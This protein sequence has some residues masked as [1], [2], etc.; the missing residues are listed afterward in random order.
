MIIK[1]NIREAVQ[2][3]ATSKQ[4]TVLALIGIIIGIGS[5]IAM[6]SIGRIVQEEALRQFKE[7][8]TDIVTIR[9]D[10][11]GGGAGG[12][13]KEAIL[14]MKEV[15]A[16]P[17]N[18]PSILQV[19]PMAFHGGDLT[20]AGKKVN[21]ATIIGV[22]QSFADLNKLKIANGRFLSDFDEYSN[23]CVLGNGAYEKMRTLVKGDVIGSSLRMGDRL[24][25]VIG[26][27][28]KMAPSSIRPFEPNDTLYIHISTVMRLKN[29]NDVSAVISRV[30]PDISHKLVQKEVTDYFSTRTKITG[31]SVQSPEDIIA[32][33]EKQMR[34]FTL[35]LG[36][37]GSISLIV[38]GVGVMNVML[39]S[40]TERRKEIGIRRALGARQSDIRGQFLIESVILSM[41]GGLFGIFLGVGGSYIASLIAKWHFTISLGAIALG[42]GV[43]S[44]VGI[45]FGFYPARQASRLDPIIALR[46]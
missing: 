26:Y 7:M 6:V 4:R 16:I 27:L 11:A 3:L 23:F 17:A 41:I 30:R 15:K 24:F 19:A 22:T 2:S 25:T 33:M 10:G 18:C 43:S 32:Q 36:A 29:S 28:E 40:V 37:I 8:G 42:F 5:V 21:T 20:C 39:V 31:I 1:T 13:K 38:G 35:L 12:N 9:K 46:S 34:M 44:V 14:E 45:F